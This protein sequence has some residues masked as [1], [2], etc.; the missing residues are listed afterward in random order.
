MN[1]NNEKFIF[2]NL[3]NKKFIFMIILIN[4]TITLMIIGDFHLGIK[5]INNSILI[6]RM[7]ILKENK[8]INLKVRL[9]K[10]KILSP[11]F[12]IFLIDKD[13]GKI[14]R[15]EKMFSPIIIVSIIQFLINSF[16]LLFYYNY[17]KKE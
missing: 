4:L 14:L 16:L 12:K 17:N 9:E 10:E 8:N 15:E 11:N 7:L 1:S 3:N 6:N 13:K 5:K 2:L